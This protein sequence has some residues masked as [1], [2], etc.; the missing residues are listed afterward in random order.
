M[1]SGEQLK[2]LTSPELIG[3]NDRFGFNNPGETVTDISKITIHIP[4][5][6]VAQYLATLPWKSF[7]TIDPVKTTG[8]HAI[9]IDK[10]DSTIY[11]LNGHRQDSMRKGI[12]IIRQ[13]DGKVIKVI[14]K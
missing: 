2:T 8:I 10:G 14:K 9:N 13:K 3:P 7:G 11:N 4:E 12:N 1:D 5:N 6:L